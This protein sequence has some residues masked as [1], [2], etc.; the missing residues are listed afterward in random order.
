MNTQKNLHYLQQE[1]LKLT[2]SNM[3]NEAHDIQQTA[4]KVVGRRTGTG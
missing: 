3:V 4:I 1:L 2:T